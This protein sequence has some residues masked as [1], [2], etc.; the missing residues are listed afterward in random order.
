M[1]KRE[2]AALFRTRLSQLQTQSGMT[3]SGFAEEI[4]IDRS[5]LSQL[6]S[7]QNPRL[8]R[9]ETLLALAARFQVS[10]DWLLGLTD[11]RG[12]ATQVL[13]TVETEQAL[14][15]ENRT[16]MERW[17]TD[18]TGQKVRYVPAWLPD[19]MRTPAV[20][21]FQ[22]ASSE[23]ERRRLQ[24][25]TDRRLMVSRM[26]ESDI[27]MCMPLQ[28]LEVFAQGRGNWT[29]I[30]AETRAEQLSH[31]ANTLDELYPAFRMYLFDGRKR[32]APPM[33]IFGYQRAAVYAG[34]TYL[35]VRSKPL[36]RDLAQGFDAHIRHA[37]VHAHEAASWVRALRVT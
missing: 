11:D 15:E 27:E 33:T 1:G 8:P 17:H 30:S 28:S 21:A 5:A 13:N 18:A 23:Q 16:A 14:D 37:E 9:A 36:V 12:I 25:Q 2:T 10:A 6:T 7:G 31:I 22:A 20:I 24:R 35:L 3:Q 34:E 4:G 29:G 32:F 26:P 19:L